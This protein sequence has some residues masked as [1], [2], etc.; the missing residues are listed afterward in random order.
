MQVFKNKIDEYIKYNK[1][2]DVIFFFF[3]FPNS[4]FEV[5]SESELDHL[6]GTKFNKNLPIYQQIT[7]KDKLRKLVFT[8]TGPKWGFYEEFID[9]SNKLNG[10]FSDIDSKIIIVENNIYFDFY[11]LDGIIDKNEFCEAIRSESISNNSPV[12]EYYVDYKIEKDDLYVMYINSHSIYKKETT[13][14]LN[15]IP[16]YIKEASRF[17]NSKNEIKINF[18]LIYSIIRDLENGKLTDTKYLIEST[19][20]YNKDDQKK[21]IIDALNTLGNHFRVSFAYDKS[22]DSDFIEKENSYKQILNDYWH[23]PS[24]RKFKI[25]KNPFESSEI[26]EVSQGYLISDIVDQI[27]KARND[28]YFSD[29]I[30]TAPTGAGKSVIFQIPA[31]YAHKNLKLIT[32]VVTPLIALMNDQVTQLNERGAKFATFI[33]SEINYEERQ[34]R[35]EAIKNG[36]YSIIYMSPESLLS[37]D[38][39]SYIGERKIGLLV[40]DEAHIVTS[41][42]RDFRVD[43]WF[44]GDFIEK[45]RKGSHLKTKKSIYTQEFPVVCLTATA[46]FGGRDDVILDLQNSLNINV[47]PE[48]IYIGN[49]RR[50]NIKFNIN[51]HQKLRF[52]KSINDEKYEVTAKRIKEFIDNKE[53][54]IVYFPYKNQISNTEIS[55]KKITDVEDWQK[56]QKY[57][58]DLDKNYKSDSFNKF[59]CEPNSVMLSTKAFGMG[60]DISDIHNVYHFAP[61][62]TLSDYI[63]EIGRAARDTSINGKAIIDYYRNDMRYAS[64]LWGLSGLRHYQIKFVI[65]KLLEL[66]E[67]NKSRNLLFSPDVFSSIFPDNTENKAKSALMLLASDL[68]DKYTY[69]VL[70]VRPSNLFSINYINVQDSIKSEFLRKY[71]KYVTMVSDYH[72]TVLNGWKDKQKEIRRT[73]GQVYEIDLGKIWEEQFKD[74]SYAQFKYKFFSGT[75]LEYEG[76]VHPRVKIIIHYIS[77]FKDVKDK[78][79]QYSKNL[80]NVFHIISTKF[81]KQEFEYLDFERLLIEE[82]GGQLSKDYIRVILEMFCLPNRTGDNPYLNP[83]VHE[84]WR[85]IR[86]IKSE[87]ESFSQ[88]YSIASNKYSYITSNIG[89]YIGEC[90]PNK[91]NTEFVAYLGIPKPEEDRKNEILFLASLL[92]MFGLAT[93]ELEGGRS[94]QVFVRIN[95]P[96]I[97]SRTIKS[98]QEYRNGQL[99]T[100]ERR[101]KQSKLLVES[102]MKTNLSNNQR[103]DVIEN[104]FL[105]RD[106]IVDQMLEIEEE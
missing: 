94:P 86:K 78:I 101:H 51:F 3:G 105:G 7:E 20:F 25:Y 30:I 27:E 67:V 42:G 102:F 47:G 90:Y 36:E 60:V 84:E 56:V 19:S 38:I 76:K 53:K 32:I 82:I 29:I 91:S 80:H 31:I 48:H 34:L 11:P 73:N 13:N 65:K 9:I 23:S 57:Y 95:D 69:K 37:N 83:Y 85:F 77:D 61:T 21:E 4:F 103:W 5:L 40:I 46:V 54:T 81:G 35:I 68:F 71:K 41:W 87:E 8:N 6:S 72:D 100:I 66:Y 75:L 44:L 104:Y 93:F 12:I 16:F 28:D 14:N 43:Y 64:T 99:T 49:T 33:N 10:D 17:L 45:T 1:D 70:V 62:G 59:K 24:F 26:V 63:Q 89:R 92:E 15:V 79:N 39:R 97:L 106:N 2:K 52:T 96:M 50:E 55:F 98:R 74:V 58:G 22:F 88:K 18:N